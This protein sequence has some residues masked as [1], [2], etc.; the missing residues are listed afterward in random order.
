MVTARTR[1]IA[2]LLVTLIL[3]A[4]GGDSSDTAKV[5]QTVTRALHALA[6]GDGATLCSLATRSGQDALARDVP[7]STC[8]KVIKLVSARL[9]P[10]LKTALANVKIGKV[11][12]HGAH[13]IVP[14]TSVTTTRGSLKGFLSAG[15]AP[16]LL[17]RQ[18]DGGWKISG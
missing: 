14:D 10:S 13:A 1:V 16:T 4:C 17:T 3:A 11:T 8:V 15:S 7:G 5:R 18:S 12:I 9:S 6:A 2:A